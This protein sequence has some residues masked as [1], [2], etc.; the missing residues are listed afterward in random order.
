[1]PRDDADIDDTDDSRTPFRIIICMSR[2]NSIWL[3]SAHYMQSDIGFKRIA[4]YKEFE[5]GG[6]D[7]SSRI[8]MFLRTLSPFY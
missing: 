4:G 7:Q 6:L 2:Q 1:M 3:L 5:L 8:S